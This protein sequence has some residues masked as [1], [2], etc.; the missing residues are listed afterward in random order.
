MRDKI[1]RVG[2]AA[3]TITSDMFGIK[4]EELQRS[5]TVLQSRNQKGA[6]A[7]RVFSPSS[8]IQ[9]GGG[10]ISDQGSQRGNYDA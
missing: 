8:T 10:G 1:S 5:G 6:A 7:K 3:A 9:S 2:E 4:A